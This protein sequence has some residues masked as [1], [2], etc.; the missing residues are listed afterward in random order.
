[1]DDLLQEIENIVFSGTKINL[2]YYINEILDT[3]YQNEIFDY[4][5]TSETDSID[6]AWQNLGTDVYS[7]EEVQLMR[8]KFM[9]E[10][11]N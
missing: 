9:S 3:E 8:I 11:A 1:M 4:F 10:M 5:R 7:R 6:D 2:D